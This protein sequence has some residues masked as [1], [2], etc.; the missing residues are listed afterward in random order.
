MIIEVENLK[1]TFRHNFTKTEILK[2]IDLEI[3]R[4]EVFGFIGPNGAG[5]TTTVKVLLGLTSPTSGKVKVLGQ[6]PNNTEVKRKIGYSPENPY[7]YE[8][9]TGQELLEFAGEIFQIPEKELPGRIEELLQKVELTEH[10]HKS[11][12]KYSKGMLQRIGLAQALIHKPELVFLDEPTSGLDPLGRQK[13]KEIILEL[14]KEGVTV[15]FCSHIL[16]DV[17]ALCDRISIIHQ[18]K[19]L[20]TGKVSELTQTDQNLESIFV[21]TIKG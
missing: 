1:K 6:E 12:R 5:K 18:G 15:F 14:K 7:F 21:K 9:L 16:A 3:E 17:E 19:I 4:G 13:I 8:Y 11:L 10:R 2:G 20:K